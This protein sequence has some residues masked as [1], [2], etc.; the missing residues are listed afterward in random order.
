MVSEL[1]ATA[2][3]YVDANDAE[4]IIKEDVGRSSCPEHPLHRDDK[5]DDRGQN[6]NR[7]RHERRNNNRD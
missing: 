3:N 2:K 4:K 5:L 1:L 6:D 7:E